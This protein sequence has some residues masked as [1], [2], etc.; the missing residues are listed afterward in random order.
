M[1]FD[2]TQLFFIHGDDYLLYSN[3]VV[4]GPG[5]GH[6]ALQKGYPEQAVAGGEGKSGMAPGWTP[7]SRLPS[8]GTIMP[9]ESQ[10]FKYL[11][12]PVSA[13]YAPYM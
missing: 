8:D 5:Y 1:L 11:V 2:F 4:G 10:F 12:I 13:L 9:Q 6:Q 3:C 7:A